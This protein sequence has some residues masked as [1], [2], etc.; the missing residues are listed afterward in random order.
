MA[1]KTGKK[2]SLGLDEN[3][4]ALLC[5]VL[6]A[7]SG[8]IFLLVEKDSKFV[9]FHALQSLFTFLFIH[10]AMFVLMFIPVLGWLV[11]SLLGIISVVLWILGM[12]KAYQGEKFKFPIVGDL[13]EKQV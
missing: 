4:E 3:I 2:T 13:A 9:K 6:M 11:S 10:V 5:Y 7:L 8:F 1:E 12:I